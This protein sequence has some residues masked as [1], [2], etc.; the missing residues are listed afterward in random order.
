MTQPT[1]TLDLEVEFSH[2]QVYIYSVAPWESDPEGHNAVLRALDDAHTS[3]RFV[4]VSEGLIDFLTAAEWNFNAPMRVETWAVEP[5]DDGENWDHVVDVDLDVHNGRLMFE[6]S[7]GRPP[8][9]CEVPSGSYR[10]RLAGR[11]YTQ[12]QEGVEGMDAYR[13]QLWPRKGDEPPTL[14]KRW[15]GFE[16]W[17]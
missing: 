17:G 2:S 4:G 11:G 13:L 8:I 14:R 12:A 7:G 5:T 10:I 9:P 15:P 3:R 6:G 1:T 16:N